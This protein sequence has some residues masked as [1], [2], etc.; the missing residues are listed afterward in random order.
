METCLQCKR[1]LFV[2]DSTVRQVYWATARKLDR[3][4]AVAESLSAAKHS[5]LKFEQGCVKIEFLWDPFLNSTLL[6]EEVE[7]YRSQAEFSNGTHVAAMLVGA[8]LWHAKDLGPMFSEGFEHSIDLVSAALPRNARDA[9]GVL[10]PSS[11][12]EGVH[13]LI[14][15]APVQMPIQSKLDPTRAAHLTPGKIET[16]NNHLQVA[17]TRHGI[18]VLWSYSLM[19]WERPSA[20]EENGIHVVENVA[21]RQADILLN[22][23]CNS[24]PSLEKYPFDRMCCNTQP[25]IKREQQVLI[26]IAALTTLCALYGSTKAEPHDDSVIHS[27]TTTEVLRAAGILSAATMSCFVADRTLVFDQSQKVPNEQIFLCLAGLIML[28]GL[29]TVRRT[30]KRSADASTKPTRTVPAQTFLSRDQTAEW[31]GWMQFVILIYH[32][33]GMSSVLWVYQL[34]RLLVASYLFMTGFGHTVYFLKTNDFSLKRVGSVLVRLN[35]LSCLLAYLMQT[36][37]SFYYFPALSSFW[38]LVVYLT[39]RI[40]HQADVVPRFLTLKIV[41]SAILVRL[42][43]QTPGLLE[44]VF[45]FFQETCNMKVDVHELRFRLSL[46]AYIVYA[47]MFAATM[48]LQLTGAAPCSTTCLA[49]QIK[50]IPTVVQ[51]M[52]VSASMLILPAYF[53]VI[54]RCPDKYDYNWWHPMISPL[55]VLAFVMLRNATQTLRDWH[56]R[57]F[58]WLGRFSLETFILQ[59]HIWLAADTKAL[60]SLGLWGRD[61]MAGL[62]WSDKLALGCEFIII[63]VFFLWTSWAVAHST[64]VLTSYIVEGQEKVGAPGLLNNFRRWP[65][66]DIAEQYQVSPSGAGHARNKSAQLEAGR[67]EKE[68]AKLPGSS[69]VADAKARRKFGLSMRLSLLLVLMWIGNW[70]RLHKV[71]DKILVRN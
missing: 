64:N 42:S 53:I 27:L 44:Y 43:V 57:L 20:H 49:T 1:L 31:K 61:S 65:A 40:R 9:D 12:R 16:M 26:L 60:L 62:T 7:H 71:L 2:G 13:D 6:G 24:E 33:T 21:D 51:V 28:G 66:R 14:L 48:Y 10:L 38:F 52:A 46:D 32:Y 5:N 63:T 67:E 30:G 50:R 25:S 3:E 35:L 4:R 58:A 34:V 29:L 36:D 11:A 54:R 70:V 15:F 19:T 8:G 69:N 18:E 37:Y 68:D 41:I 56:S 59:Y 55:P 17:V 45:K 23:R 39:V 47:G 22:M